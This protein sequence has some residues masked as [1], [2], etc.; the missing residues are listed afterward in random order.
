MH[1][2]ELVQSLLT[3]A[4]MDEN[5]FLVIAEI[6]VSEILQDQLDAFQTAIEGKGISLHC[7]LDK[8]IWVRADKG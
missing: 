5:T 3:L 6:P 4:R 2:T 8:D 1:L 7:E